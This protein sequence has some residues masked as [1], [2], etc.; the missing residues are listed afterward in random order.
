M[1]VPLPVSLPDSPVSV[2]LHPIWKNPY[3][4]HETLLTSGVI[5]QGGMT[6]ITSGEILKGICILTSRLA[7]VPGRVIG[8][9]GGRAVGA[10]GGSAIVGGAKLSNTLFRTAFE[11]QS[12]NQ[13][14][15]E[16]AERARV[17]GGF[18]SKTIVA[19]STGPMLAIPTALG[20]VFDL[21][22]TIK[23]ITRCSEHQAFLRGFPGW[24]TS[25]R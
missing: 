4:A 17:L 19:L 5:Y 21:E 20:I 8:H 2:I 25:R 1:A 22:N 13:Y 15:E 24:H 23:A 11:P 18:A 6:M 14:S 7:G 3:D 12:V 16:S 9:F 10:V